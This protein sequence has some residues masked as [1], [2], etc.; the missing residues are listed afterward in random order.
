MRY[1]EGGMK[2]WDYNVP[3]NWEPTTDREWVWWLARKINY[4]DW[5][6]LNETRVRQYFPQLKRYLHPGKRRMLELYLY[7]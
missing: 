3:E 7:E 2:V 4:D 1:N 6:G 5:E